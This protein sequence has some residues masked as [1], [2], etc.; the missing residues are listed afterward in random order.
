MI[1]ALI[2]IANTAEIPV[3]YRDTPVVQLLEY[4]NLDKPFELHDKAEMVIGMCMDNRISLRI[5]Q[6]FAFVIRTGGGN[7]KSSDFYVSFAIAVGEAKCVTV[8]GHSNCGMAE[9]AQCREKFVTNMVERGGWEKAHA[10]DYFDEYSK[11][12]EIGDEIQFVLEETRRLR[13]IYPK[14]KIVPMM[15]LVEDHKLYIIRHTDER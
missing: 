10:E 5:P 14:I 2:S 8:I 12:F 6:N 1:N 9:I 11:K 4:H 3:E 7:L 13:E 15:Y